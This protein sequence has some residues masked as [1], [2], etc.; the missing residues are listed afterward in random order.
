MENHWTELRISLVCS[1]QY[2]FLPR[3]VLDNAPEL[4]PDLVVKSQEFLSTKY[5]DELAFGMQSDEIWEQFMSWLK[6][7][8]IISDDV[9]TTNM[10]TNKYI[11]TTE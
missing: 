3:L 2:A 11:E 7:N 1:L 4:S 5:Q 6:A 9:E 8:E 10:Y